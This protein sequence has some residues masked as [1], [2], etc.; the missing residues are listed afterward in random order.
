M[1]QNLEY[2]YFLQFSKYTTELQLINY[3]PQKLVT[4]GGTANYQI[5]ITEATSSG[6]K[7][8]AESVVDFN[9]DGK[10]NIW[11]VDQDGNLKEI[12]PD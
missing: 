9:G 5:M 8:K 3:M 2:A 10:N 4:A 6:F 1:I 12:Q 11:E 7:A